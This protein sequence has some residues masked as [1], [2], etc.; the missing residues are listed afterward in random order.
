MCNAKQFAEWLPTWA[1]ILLPT[2][3]AILYIT[4]GQ[5]DMMLPSSN[6]DRMI[7]TISCF[8]ALLVPSVHLMGSVPFDGK[9]MDPM[10][11]MVGT[12]HN[13]HVFTR[14]DMILIKM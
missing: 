13:K 2:Q 9:Q 4:V 14:C 5:Y 7:E 8:D 10:V 12:V 1:S 3:A 11:D 6:L